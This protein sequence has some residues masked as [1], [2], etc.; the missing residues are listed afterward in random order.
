[1]SLKRI[2]SAVCAAAVLVSTTFS[3]LPLKL[4][5]YSYAYAVPSNYEYTVSASPVVM[6]VTSNQNGGFSCEVT[7]NISVQDVINGTTT[8]G[9]LRDMYSGITAKGFSLVNSS[10]A[11]LTEEDLHTSISLLSGASYDDWYAV[12]DEETMDFADMPADNDDKVVQAITFHIYLDSEDIIRLGLKAGDNVILNYDENKPYYQYIHSGNPMEMTVT[13]ATWDNASGR[14]SSY[15][16]DITIAGVTPGETTVGELKERYEGI[17]VNGYSFIDS[18]VEGMTAAD[19]VPTIV[20]MTGSSYSWNAVYNTTHMTFSEALAEIPDEDVVQSIGF[21]V[22]V[23]DNSFD[24]LGL[25]IGD[26]FTVNPKDVWNANFSFDEASGALSIDAFTPSD[27]TGKVSYEFYFN[28]EELPSYSSDVLTVYP[29]VILAEKHLFK[30]QDITGDISITVKALSEEREILAVSS[31][32]Y[33][34]SY[35][36]CDVNSSLASPSSAYMA[37]NNKVYWSMP[38]GETGSF[39]ITKIGET[40]LLLTNPNKGC[41]YCDWGILSYWLDFYKAE[42]A[43]II[44]YSVD[45]QGDISAPYNTTYS[46]LV[47]TTKG[48][49]AEYSLDSSTGVLTFKNLAYDSNFGGQYNDRRYN[50]LVDGTKISST[51]GMSNSLTTRYSLMGDI[52]TYNLQNTDSQIVAGEHTLSINAVD[53]NSWNDNT[54]LAAPNDTFAF[55]YNGGNTNA[56]L[57]APTNIRVS[58]SPYITDPVIVWDS[59]DGAVGY[60]YR[61]SYYTMDL[62]NFLDSEC[63]YAAMYRVFGA[64]GKPADISI[65]SVDKDGNISE[66]ADFSADFTTNKYNIRFDENGVLYW[67][68]VDG[69][70]YYLISID[71]TTIDT[72]IGNNSANYKTNMAQ[73]GF[74]PGT[75]TFEI[76]AVFEDNSTM[77]LGDIEYSYSGGSATV[78]GNTYTYTD[79]DDGTVTITGGVIT[80]PK[81]EIP[82]ELGGKSVSAIGH[83]AF[84]VNATITELTIPEGVKSIDWYAFYSCENMSGVTLPDSL[85]YIDS[86]AFEHCI[87]LETITIPANVSTIKGGAFARCDLLTS[88]NVNEGNEQFVSVNGV[89]FSKDMSALVAYPGGIN[90]KFTVPATVNHIG[91]AAFYGAHGLDAVEILGDLDFIGFEAFALC[92]NL[93]DVVINDGVN[94]VGY[95]AFRGCDGIKLL[96]VPQSVT[97][98]GN[99]AFGFADYDG[100]KISDFTLRGYKDSAVYFY[101]LRHDLPFICI[102]EADDANKPFDADNSTEGEVETNPDASEDDKITT[103]I[104][105]PAFNMKDKSEAGVGLDLTKIQVKAK[106]IYDEEGVAR[107]EAAL[108]TEISLNKH[109]NLL[110]LTL[111]HNDK[112]ISNDYDGLVEVVIPI[113]AGHR[114]KDFYCYR[115]LDDGT[116]ELI[117]GVRKDDSYVVYLEHFSVYSLV[118]DEEH[119]CSFSENWSNDANGHWHECSCGMKKDEAKHTASEWITAK[120]ATSTENGYRYKECS[121]CGYILDEETLTYGKTKTPDI[122]PAG[123]T[124]Y[125]SQI[126]TITC[127]TEGAAIYYTTDGTEPTAESTLYT[128]SFTLTESKTIKAIAVMND[129]DDSN[130]ASAEYTIRSVPF[131]SVSQNLNLSDDISVNFYLDLADYVMDDN[132]A[133][134]VFSFKGNQ[135]SVPVSEGEKSGDVYKFSFPVAAAEMTDTITG[136]LYLGGK[137]AGDAFSSS[138][139][140]YAEYILTNGEDYE[141][142]LPLVK[143]MLNYGAQAQLFFEYNTNDL[144]NSILDEND[145]ALTPITADVLKDYKYEAA[146]NDENIDFKGQVIGLKNKITAKFY[147]TGE[148]TPEMCKVNGEA[149]SAEDLC[150]DDNGTYIAVHNITPGNFDKQYVITV[151]NVTVS[152]AS[153]FSYLYTALS[154]NR[155]ELYDIAYALYAYNLA[156][157][158]YAE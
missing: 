153:V 120:E 17:V 106:E 53:S 2:A 112:D 49:N 29:G 125:G 127:D 85:E 149:I 63:D 110:D 32:E 143:A 43:D 95:W 118:A 137:P 12:T 56:N 114:D 28:D 93:N 42:D 39:F 144:A 55:T 60:I 139:K 62:Y 8:V 148:I 24:K 107:A 111:I 10:V 126:I 64:S 146:D 58:K 124:Y 31:D 121:I 128:E 154:Y 133:A 77:K 103:I 72:C 147:F 21:S 82:A 57:S 88:I 83:H 46:A 14:S 90:G 75:Y 119:T 70:S 1:M 78:D 67:D 96:T 117:P 84:A 105:T 115:I 33:I 155:T 20:V 27:Y 66:W 113:P 9:E 97:N 100:N 101:A 41:N 11:G 19:L 150:E 50:V 134:V 94:Y 18:T 81:L 135:T 109:Y 102:G 138:V 15:S 69:A 91:D 35:D 48:W 7:A 141:K 89:V 23:Q 54:A 38:Y 44:I 116:K 16:E 47:N 25:E 71:G 132:T 151:G 68:A 61:F 59:V 74:Q 6:S 40:E 152:N 37:D 87:K 129:M 4:S 80:T 65:C 22:S 130:V 13:A 122:S 145:K 52:T 136:Q 51:F 34:Y 140:N 156:A 157:E 26:S 158:N 3:D 142:E 98:I 86:W 131:T 76:C 36:G 79:N 99:E 104:A 73:N 123:G 92:A 30:K 5:E 45:A 108:G